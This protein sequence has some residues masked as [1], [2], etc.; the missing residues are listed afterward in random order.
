LD[1]IGC[2]HSWR[3]PAESS[4]KSSLVRMQELCADC[5]ARQFVQQRLE[6]EGRAAGLKGFE[7][8]KKVHL[9]AEEFTVDNGLVTPSFKLKRPQLRK[10]FQ[11][12]IQK[13][14]SELQERESRL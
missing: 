1:R 12:S 13:M 2:D 9:S 14:Y 5:D 8:V 3:S 6:H 10:D 11:I 7:I 4:Q